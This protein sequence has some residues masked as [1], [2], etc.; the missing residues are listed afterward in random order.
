MQ[1]RIHFEIKN[2]KN[3]SP[4]HVDKI[5]SSVLLQS[6]VILSYLMLFDETESAFGFNV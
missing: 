4:P 6:Y 3:S 5:M 2:I 1:L